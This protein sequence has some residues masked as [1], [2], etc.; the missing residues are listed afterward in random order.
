MNRT[1]Y[2][3]FKTFRF[4]VTKYYSG[5]SSKYKPRDLERTIRILWMSS[6]SKPFSSTEPIFVKLFNYAS[7]IR[8]LKATVDVES[9]ILK[10]RNSS[11]QN[12]SQSR[13]VKLDPVIVKKVFFRMSNDLGLKGHHFRAVLPE[14]AMDSM[15]GSTSSSCPDYITPKRLNFKSVSDQYSYWLKTGDCSFFDAYMIGLSWRTQVSRSQKLKYRLFY[16]LP[17]LVQ[18]AERCLFDGMFKHF[19][20]NKMTPYAYSNVYTDLSKRWLKWQK[21][22]FIYSLDLEAFDQRISHVLLGHIFNFCSIFLKLNENERRM[23]NQIKDYHFNALICTSSNGVTCTF[24]K[25]SGLLSGSTLTNLFGSLVNLFQIY[26]YM[27]EHKLSI[28]PDYVSVHGDDCILALDSKVEIN[29]IA[30]YYLAHFSAVISVEKSEIF[31]PGDKVYY[32]GHFFD[33]V[34]RYL[35]ERYKMQLIMSENYIPESVM[36]A[37]DRVSSKFCSILFKCSDGLSVFTEYQEKLKTL[38]N[39]TKLPIEY[40]LFYEWEGT[41][42]QG[43]RRTTDWMENGWRQQ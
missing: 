32:L 34:G 37:V 31:L 13:H 18:L 12:M 1:D 2:K 43:I 6:K 26:Y 29:S 8:R 17:H 24:R 42:P 15:P 20:K 40:R 16:P 39:V 30:E 10:A 41:L 35:P 21:C 25:N 38:L 28:C 11:F 27:F 36:S 9:E 3:N 7:I 14:V 19:D 33:N 23:F 5:L 4:S 22:K